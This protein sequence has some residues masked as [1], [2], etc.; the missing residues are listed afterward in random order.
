MVLGAARQRCNPNTDISVLC[1]KEMYSFT[2]GLGVGPFGSGP[3]L[4]HYTL[5]LFA[6]LG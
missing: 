4:R 5:E 2:M 6:C 3:L 1:L